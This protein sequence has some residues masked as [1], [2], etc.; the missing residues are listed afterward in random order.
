MKNVTEDRKIN[1][2]FLEHRNDMDNG[3]S[4]K[5]FKYIRTDEFERVKA[6]FT[7]GYLAVQDQRSHSKVFKILKF[8]QHIVMTL[9][10]IVVLVTVIGEYNLY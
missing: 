3:R 6:A 9:V 2:F 7:E 5:N 1:K 4:P 8:A 10:G